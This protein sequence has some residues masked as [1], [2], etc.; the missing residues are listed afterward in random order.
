MTHVRQQ[1]RD[2]ATSLLTGLNLTGSEC[3]AM[4]SYPTDIRRLPVLLV[5]ILAEDSAPADIGA[6]RD[7]S[8]QMTLTVEA[9]ARGRDFD[10][11]LDAVAVEVEKAIAES[12]GLG[13]LC[14]DIFLSSSR[15]DFGDRSEHRTGVLTMT[16]LA[17]VV[18]P[19]ADP[20]SVS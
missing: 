20:E 14:T 1:V 17:S 19:E 13:G 7:L 12:H 8:R 3:Y 18:G 9:Q 2:A 15:I 11:K 5:Y 4:R 16:F 6:D 10:D